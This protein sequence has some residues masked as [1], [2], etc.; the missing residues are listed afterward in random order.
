MRDEE[1]FHF[2]DPANRGDDFQNFVV[3]SPS[4]ANP[5]LV[6]FVWCGKDGAIDLSSTRQGEA[7]DDDEK[8]AQS[9]VLAARHSDRE[10]E[11]VGYRANAGA[12]DGRADAQ[13]AERRCRR[14]RALPG[15]RAAEGGIRRVQEVNRRQ[16]PWVSSGSGRLPPE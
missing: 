6:S 3:Q 5:E 11:A 13:R 7:D 14:R 16:N 9:A 10:V 12:F 15:D 1:A 4:L 8:T 2:P